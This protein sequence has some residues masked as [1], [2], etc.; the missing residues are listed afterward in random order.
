MKYSKHLILVAI[1]LLSDLVSKLYFKNNNIE[2]AKYFSF[3]YAENTGTGFGLFRSNNLLF[4]FITLIAIGL[5]LYN[6]KKEKNFQLG[7]D[8]IL[9]GAFGNLVNRLVYGYVVDFI[10]F[11]IWPVFNLADTF[12]VI[13]VLYCIYFSLKK[14]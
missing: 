3:T 1:L 10:D 6:Y 8:F 12:I 9:A 5:I 2:I 4:I 13:G 11:K 7:L 14:S